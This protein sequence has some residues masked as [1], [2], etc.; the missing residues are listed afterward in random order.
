MSNGWLP[1]RWRRRSPRC[2]TVGAAESCSSL[3]SAG[4]NKL[5]MNR[6]KAHARR[7][8]NWPPRASLE[9]GTRS[10]KPGATHKGSCLLLLVIIGLLLSAKLTWWPAC[11]RP[12]RLS[13][14]LCSSEKNP[15][16][17]PIKSTNW[18]PILVW[19]K[20]VAQFGGLSRPSAAKNKSPAL[21]RPTRPAARP[22]KRSPLCLLAARCWLLAARCSLLAC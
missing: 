5:A 18:L 1:R 4:S 22:H 10:Q 21:Q 8:T 13:S 15:L 16:C 6:P 9:L 7:P 3:R 11:E 2:S 14:A 17:S 19:V 20:L 12:A